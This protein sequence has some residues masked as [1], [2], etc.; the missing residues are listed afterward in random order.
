M[1]NLRPIPH[2][3]RRLATV[4]TGGHQLQKG[5]VLRYIQEL[6]GYGSLKAIEIYT[7]LSK[8]SLANVKSP[9]DEIEARQRIE[10]HDIKLN[11]NK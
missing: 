7:H 10:N 6:L 3:Q 2:F 8:N 9:L 11:K 4:N 1:T 5:T